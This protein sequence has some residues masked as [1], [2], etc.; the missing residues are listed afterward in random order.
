M[1]VVEH[2]DLKEAMWN[3]ERGWGLNP[4]E[5][6]ELH[7]GAI[8]SIHVVSMKPGAVRGNH[9]HVGASEWI[10]V[11]SGEVKFAWRDGEALSETCISVGE[12]YPV[13]FRVAPGVE[14]A[15]CNIS[16]ETIYLLC[17][18]DLKSYETVRGSS[19]L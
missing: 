13:M 12:K 5:V 14:H 17:F 9:H 8:P 10:L 2:V 19:L 7:G 3:D 6:V 1:V 15:V 16:D 18:S 4:I 11:C